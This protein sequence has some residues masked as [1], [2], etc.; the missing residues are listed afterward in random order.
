[1]AQTN[2]QESAWT[3]DSSPSLQS[4]TLANLRKITQI[5]NFSEEQIFEMEVV[6]NVLPFKANNY[7]IEQLIDWDNVP[8]DS[9]FNLTFPQKHMLKTEHYDMMASVLK[10]DPDRKQ[11][12]EMANKIRL[13]LNPH[14]AGQMELN[15]PMLKDG[16]KLYGM[17]HKY[18]ETTLFFPSQGQTCHAYCSFCFRWPQFVGMDEMKF[19]M[20][21]GDDL[22]QY[23]R[24][25]PE[26]SDILFTGGDPMIMKASLFATYIDK[27][28]DAN[29]PNLK[30]IRI[31]TKALSYWP[32]KFTSDS[33]SEETLETFRRIK[34]KGI[35]VAL[36]G[37]FNHLAEL[38]TDSVKLAIEKVRE[39][40]VQ[41]RTQSP[42]LTN[43][44]DDADMWAQMWQKQVELGCIPYYMFV[45]RDTGAQHYFGVSLVKA[46]EIFQQ[47]IQKVSGLARTVRGP[48]MSATP[49]KVQVD[50]V[51]EINGT[52]VIVLRMLQGRNP[53]WVNRPFFAKYDENA[54]WLDDLKPAFEDKFF[55]EDELK[56][57][58]EQ[59]MKNMNS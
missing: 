8:G 43:I 1:M 6:G 57:I 32:Y 2:Q 25:H 38:K 49:G 52:K 31:G 35:H 23:V 59:K 55:F 29:L 14:P 40:G 24:E 30:T 4:V 9:M 41:I 45:V 37:H 12:Q 58:K 39:T 20:K 33:D 19:A 46:H 5:E 28:L 47:A 7:V 36:M 42:L 13:E 54:I 15:V 21:E 16:T 44:N 48:S 56:Q 3:V 10:N 51:A 26:I 27:I 53:E 18:K 50:G 34:S 22:A 11:I 17:Q